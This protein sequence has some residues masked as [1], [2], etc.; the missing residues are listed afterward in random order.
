MFV[1]F[2]SESRDEAGART[3]FQRLIT[4]L[5]MA[6]VPNASEVAYPGGGD[7]GIDTYVGSLDD[8]IVVWQSKFFT[9]WGEPQQKQIRD[10]F[11]QV[12]TKADE[13]GFK[14][15][16]WPLC[17]PSILPPDVQ[18]WFDG[19]KQREGHRF[20]YVC[21]AADNSRSWLLRVR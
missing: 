18:K 9:S 7:W 12:M 21:Q 14:V 20:F 13:H 2:L 4:D 11:K 1:R 3:R 15:A 17:V 6:K 10:S 19:W 5:V 16:A 8:G